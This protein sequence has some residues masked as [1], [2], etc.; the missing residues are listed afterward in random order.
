MEA[1]AQGKLQGRG[2]T[3]RWKHCPEEAAGQGRHA[4]P[5]T[6]PRLLPPALQSVAKLRTGNLPPGIPGD[7]VCD[8]RELCIPPRLFFQRLLVPRVRERLNDERI[9]SVP[10][11]VGSLCL[12][13]KWQERSEERV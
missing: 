5:E 9:R 3:P 4:P 2:G 10:F 12:S 8:G 7:S 6:L 11:R 1:A 13:W